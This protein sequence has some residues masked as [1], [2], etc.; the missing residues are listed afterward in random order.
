MVYFNSELKIFSLTKIEWNTDQSISD[1]LLGLF[2]I[3]NDVAL[4]DT[5][6]NLTKNYINDFFKENN[7]VEPVFDLMVKRTNDIF[8]TKEYIC[9]LSQDDSV[10]YLHGQIR[11]CALSNGS[12]LTMLGIIERNDYDDCIGVSIHV[13]IQDKTEVKNFS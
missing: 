12:W 2:P 5:I 7:D 6:Y 1:Y 8:T 9:E 10:S 4:K 3:A 11:G 13:I